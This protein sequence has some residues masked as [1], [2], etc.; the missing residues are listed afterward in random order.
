M[1]RVHPAPDGHHQ[2]RLRRLLAG[3]Q[4]SRH[5]PTPRVRQLE[6][7]RQPGREDAA[8]VQAASQ[9]RASLR[10]YQR[11]AKSRVRY[12][13]FFVFF[14]FFYLFIFFWGGGEGGR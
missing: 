13:C 3:D 9:P 11:R 5:Q 7:R 6:E 1:S 8:Q 4:T 12:D 10:S 2:P 14:V